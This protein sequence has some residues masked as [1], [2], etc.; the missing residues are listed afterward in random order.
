MIAVDVVV[1]VHGKWD[2]T[3]RC[4]ETLRSRDAC[5]RAVIVVDDASL[6]DTAARLR[7]RDD[8]VP[9]FLER[10]VGFSAACNAGAR[11]ATADA[12]LFLNNDTLVPPGAIGRLA[13]E[14]TAD[15]T[16]GAAGPRLLYAD[17]TVQS[18]GGTVA[19]STG[20]AARAFISLDGDAP[21]VN[22]PGD[23]IA[24]TGAALLVRREAFDA[25][26]GF[27]E[28]YRNGFEDVDL[29][30]KL[31]TAGWRVRYVPEAAIVH[32]EGASRGRAHDEEANRGAFGQRWGPYL[33]MI[34]RF[35]LS[36]P[37]CLL[38]AWKNRAPIDA[39][40][41]GRVAE[42]LRRH[43]GARATFGRSPFAR[44]YAAIAAALD[45]RALVRIAYAAGGP[46]D[47]TWIAPRDAADARTQH[48]PPE[49]PIWVPSQRAKRFAIDAGVDPRRVAIVHLGFA[50]EDPPPRFDRVVVV[51]TRDAPPARLKAIER[52]VAPASTLVIDAEAADDAARDAVRSART[53]VFASAGDAWGLLGGEA[54]AAG[55]LVVAPVDAPFLEY[56]PSDAFVGAESA[57][58]VADAAA[59]VRA[60]PELFASHALRAR[61][62]IVRR[63]PDVY[64][65][66]RVRE[67]ARTFV[68]GVP[69]PRAVAITPEIARALR[70]GPAPR[71]AR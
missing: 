16:I 51:T 28:V 41:R 12:V 56:L 44:G 70:S 9:V 34:P 11:R 66:H 21:E 54:L 42:M 46:R 36:D 20:E 10:N 17:G 62:E 71:T 13:Q 7:E 65:G 19:A 38:V 4:L 39:L 29:G 50:C 45:R 52:A 14:L 40:A 22:V 33:D 2:L 3:E 55:A 26:G 47:V 49:G 23:Y 58:A 63:L 18:A 64:A 24:L 35:A 67:L 31:W 60:D 68:H 5:V 61:R 43:A 48:V 57:D 8:V 53:V 30:M 32:L 37:P 69:D 6:D 59:A 25:V 15:A 1:P 27:D